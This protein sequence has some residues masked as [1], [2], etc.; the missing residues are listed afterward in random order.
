[1]DKRIKNKGI[2]LSHPTGN[3]FLRVLGES[4]KDSGM[5]Y[6]FYTTVACFPGTILYN[7]SKYKPMLEIRRRSFD[8]SLRSYTRSWPWLEAG[9]LLAGKFKW[10]TL[11]THEKGM[12]SVDAIYRNLDR[13]VARDLTESLGKNVEG[14]YAY[15]DGAYATFLQAKKLNI[16]CLYDLPIGYWRTARR[17]LRHEY[18]NNPEWSSTLS[19]WKDSDSKLYRKDNELG[20]ADHIFVAS[21]FT[22][23]TLADYPGDL[24]SVSVIPYGFPPAVA[25]RA[26]PPL[27]GRALRL[28]FVGGLSQRKGI[29]YLFDAVDELQD[30]VELT[31]VGRK[32][33]QD[34][35]ALNLA[36]SRHTWMPTLPHEQILQLMQEH[37]ILVF[38]SLFEGF[39]LVITEAMSQGTPVITT[40]RTAGADFITHGEN[41]WIVEA[42]NTEVLIKQIE[43]LLTQPELIRQNGQSALETA[44]KRPWSLYGEELAGKIKK[45]LQKV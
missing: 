32:A 44:R 35:S 24:P 41:G 4:L 34:C 11:T 27:R 13:R 1:M 10:Y 7:L 17:L 3:A 42:G 29:S 20:L 9:R 26:Y 31:V 18:E 39:G 19:G 45:V 16:I 40:E 6:A 14:V 28:L 5:L 22:K 43:E 2:L 21:S 37:D 15:E 8:E 23:Q 12:L 38:P 33:V 36:L 25:E 30:K